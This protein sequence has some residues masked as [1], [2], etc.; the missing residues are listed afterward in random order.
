MTLSFATL[1]PLAWFAV[2]VLVLAIAIALFTTR[3]IG[4]AVSE[5][6]AALKYA[7]QLDRDAAYFCRLFT[8][9]HHDR[10]N[11]AFPDFA[12]FARAERAHDEEYAP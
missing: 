9:G 11:Q 7:A 10:L 5:H 8:G 2:I 4:V 3:R 1:A 6:R 12:D